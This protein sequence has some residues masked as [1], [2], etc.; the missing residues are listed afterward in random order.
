[1]AAGA[2]AASIVIKINRTAMVW[3]VV[4][5][6]LCIDVFS[7]SGV[8]PNSHTCVAFLRRGKTVVQSRSGWFNLLSCPVE[9]AATALAITPPQFGWMTK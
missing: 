9:I 5:C 2:Q 7:S 4:L 3:N 1:V 6:G 8:D